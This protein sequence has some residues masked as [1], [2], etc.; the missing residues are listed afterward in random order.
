MGISF[1]VAPGVRLRTT[2]RGLRASVGPRA[3]RIHVGAGRT[4]VS[5]GLGPVSLY[6]SVGGS[7]AR[8]RRG[9]APSSIAARERQLRQAA[10]LEQAHEL[11]SAFDAIM[12]AHRQEFPAAAA[13]VARGPA[14]VDQGAILQRCEQ[15][16]LQGI[17]V[18]H[19]S[20]R[21]A[22]RLHAS[23]AAA[24][25]IAEAVSQ[26][27]EQYASL[28]RE[29]DGQWRRLLANDPDVVA[30]TL[31][32]SFEDNEAPAAVTSVHGA[33]VSAV[34]L[35]P[36]P[37]AIPERM[38]ER[39]AAGNLSLRKLAR[40]TRDGFYYSLV[41]GHV[42]VTVREAMA[43]APSIDTVL[44][45]AVRR[46]APDVYGI[47]HP[48]CILAAQFRRQQLEG[49]RW[50]IASAADIVSQA[51]ADL[52]MQRTPSGELR[53]LDLTDEQGLAGLLQ[54]IDLTDV[55]DD[56]TARPAATPRPE[57]RQGGEPRDTD[58]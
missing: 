1:K 39:T 2:S 9:P 56:V 3:A 32:E 54:A 19:R 26:Q 58:G 42:L 46:S 40:T 45:A 41:C 4:G 37:G 53:A 13:P 29:L 35:V 52:Q 17:G 44:V 20:D 8:S 5:T 15:E 23:R 57:G 38:P 49:V 22:A 47:H 25:Q 12:N 50:D 43:V 30:G 11:A 28:Q 48:E 55:N 34:V 36:D 18:L 27:N 33:E 14:P 7:R 10:R 6:E 31:A 21:A 51:S 24:A 16:A